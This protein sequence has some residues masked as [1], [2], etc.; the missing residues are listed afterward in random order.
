VPRF[1]VRIQGTNLNTIG[2]ELPLWTA[3]G[4]TVSASGVADQR[5]VL[6]HVAAET[7]E[8]ARRLV[9]GALPGGD[10]TLGHVVRVG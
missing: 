1:T 5:Y 8:D 6:A 4:V 9:I 2:L 7:A 10:Y 3:T